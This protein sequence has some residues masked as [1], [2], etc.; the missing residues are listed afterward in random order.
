MTIGFTDRVAL[1]VGAS[2][3]VGLTVANRFA[4]EGATVVLA[5]TAPA[6]LEHAEVLRRQYPGSIDVVHAEV[7]DPA[8]IR[9]MV[10][11][12]LRMHGRLDYAFNNASPVEPD[13]SGRADVTTQGLSGLW[14]CMK[15]EIAAL[16]GQGGAIVN[17]AAMMSTAAGQRR[18]LAA[19]RTAA[20]ECA[21]LGIRV[22]AVCPVGDDAMAMDGDPLPAGKPHE[23][24][25]AVLWLCNEH[26]TF[27]GGIP[28]GYP[29]E[30]W[31][32]EATAKTA[33]CRQH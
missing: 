31:V 3:S 20:M 11:A 2:S 21:S 28:A 30:G 15:Y 10:F 29:P 32:I 27:M 18:L 23:V 8:A 19:T 17:N 13:A 24:A 5:D 4:I 9:S 25:E 14:S 7:G 26:S 33:P 22:N 6:V 16:L 12:A 1:V